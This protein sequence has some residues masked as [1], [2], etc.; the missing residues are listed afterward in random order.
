MAKPHRFSDEV[1]DAAL[2]HDSIAASEV[3][4][5]KHYKEFDED[6]NR[7]MLGLFLRDNGAKRR[8]LRSRDDTYYG[9]SLADYERIIVDIGFQLATTGDFDSYHETTPENVHRETW[10]L[11][12]EPRRAILLFYDTFLGNLKGGKYYYNWKPVEDISWLDR[13][14][15]TSSGHTTK[16]GIWIGDHDCREAIRRNIER[17]EQFGEFVTPWVERQFHRLCHHMDHRHDK[18]ESFQE[19]TARYKQLTEDRLSLVDV[20]ILTAISPRATG[21]RTQQ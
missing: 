1:V 16:D 9:I 20:S 8:I 19:C 6:E 14:G 7:G 11:W 18:S 4:I 10:K 2:Q 3:V 12:F 15:C 21:Q 5:G 17:M 13:C